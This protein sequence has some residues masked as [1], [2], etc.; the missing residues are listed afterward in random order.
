MKS[1]KIRAV[2]LLKNLRHA[3]PDLVHQN[4]RELNDEQEIIETVVRVGRS[5]DRGDW[6]GCRSC[7]TDNLFLDCDGGGHDP[8]VMKS[9]DVIDEWKK[10][11][12]SYSSSL[13][14]ISSFEVDIEEETAVCSSLVQLVHMDATSPNAGT[15]KVQQSFGCYTDTLILD[16]YE[17]KI[18]KRIYRQNALVTL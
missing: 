3:S 18:S 5:A 10:L 12:K 11:S 14:F 6:T 9:D 4:L 1:M 13:H 7:F 8:S 15:G 2:K 17:W 16:D